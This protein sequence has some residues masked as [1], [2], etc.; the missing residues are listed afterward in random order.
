MHPRLPVG[1]AEAVGEEAVWEARTVWKLALDVR[2]CARALVNIYA[3][4]ATALA[5]WQSMQSH[6]FIHG[7]GHEW[8]PREAD[9]ARR[10]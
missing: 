2:V 5:V 7:L 8:A 4:I 1:A 3:W 10:H 6:V 9:V